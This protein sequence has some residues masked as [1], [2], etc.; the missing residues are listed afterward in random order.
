MN[1]DHKNKA[2]PSPKSQP[3]PLRCFRNIATFVN[4]PSENELFQIQAV[5]RARLT[6]TDTKLGRVCLQTCPPRA[7]GGGCVP[8]ATGA[9]KGEAYE[10]HA[11]A[12]VMSPGSPADMPTQ[13]GNPQGPLPDK[14]R[15]P[16]DVRASMAHISKYHC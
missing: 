3:G 14:G 2:S 9:R 4:P 8:A 7:G 10:F 1:T 16:T 13:M 5:T 11:Q 12:S 15:S 6:L